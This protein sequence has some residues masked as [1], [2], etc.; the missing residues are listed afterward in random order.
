MGPKN[1]RTLLIYIYFTLHLHYTYIFYITVPV[2]TY[3]FIAFHGY[4]LG[5]YVSKGEKFPS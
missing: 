1:T 3:L 5:I 4:L 2:E